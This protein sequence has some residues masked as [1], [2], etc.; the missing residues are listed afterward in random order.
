MSTPSAR[1][2]ACASI[3]DLVSV[4]IPAFN[5]EPFIRRAIASA[6]AQTYSAI[7]IIVVDD[8][9][10]DR[11]AEMVEELA[12]QDSRIQLV[13]Q[14]NGGVAAARN[15]GIDRARGAYV[16]PL[17]ADDLWHPKKLRHQMDVIADSSGRFVL[18]YTWYA[19]IDEAD[20]VI[21]IPGDLPA[22]EGWAYAALVTGNFIG[23]AS[24]PLMRRSI[25]A[26][27]GGYDPSL[28]RMNA[29][30]CEDWKLY[31]AMA[32]RGE[33]GVVPNVLVGYRQSA[34]SMSGSVW[35]MKRSYD[36]VLSQAQARHPELPRRLFR[37]SK[38]YMY[39]WLAG[40]CAMRSDYLDAVWLT[41][42][43]IRQD[44]GL[45]LMPWFM[46]KIVR[47]ALRHPKLLPLRKLRDAQLRVMK[48]TMR[49]NELDPGSA[50]RLVKK[51][52]SFPQ[53]CATLPQRPAA[54]GPGVMLNRRGAYIKSI[55]AKHRPLPPP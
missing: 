3:G 38:G 11:T 20:R 44:P 51:G 55:L 35:Q 23:N 36:L 43:S 25:L 46:R 52:M 1:D 13:R 42:L 2:A 7:E 54:S 41:L 18:V 12:E 50:P 9:S 8:G 16:A 31:L 27:I 33:I 32:E 45:L 49:H 22:H 4:V 34:S 19:L 15:A 28:R 17:D 6:Q 29:Q 21:A 5:A 26:E 10:T 47:A 40:K 48:Q 39:Q 53:L 24:A 14:S 30:G 37:W